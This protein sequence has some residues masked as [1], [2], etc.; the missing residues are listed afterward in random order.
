MYA[1]RFGFVYPSFS[2]YNESLH[3]NEFVFALFAFAFVLMA[4]GGYVINDYYDVQI[5]TINKPGK[6]IIGRH[7]LPKDALIFYRILNIAGVIAGCASAFLMGLPLLGFIFALY[8]SGL[9]FYSYSLKR[10][11]L[12]GNLIIAFFVALVPLVSGVTEYSSLMKS[13]DSIALVLAPCWLYGLIGIYSLSIFALLTT[14]AREIVKDT[15]DMDGDKSANSRTLPI[16]F[17][18]RAVKITVTTLLLVVLFFFL[19][20]LLFI[21]N[22]FGY[23]I[24]FLLSALPET[25]MIFIVVSVIRAQTNRDYHNISQ[26][27]KFM[28][29]GCT[30]YLAYICY[31]TEGLCKYHIPLK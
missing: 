1:V 20:L 24:A 29:I 27:I 30:L 14:L 19:G 18:T 23:S 25:L 15:E 13:M 9:W 12:T 21:W 3:V 11:L 10:R 17:G 26:W 6:V 16:V 7:I 31:I 5:D 28:M 4:A 22:Q 2:V 8:I